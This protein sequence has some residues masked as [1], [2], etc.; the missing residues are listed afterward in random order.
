MYVCIYICRYVYIYI[1]TY[2]CV[3]VFVFVCVYISK[4]QLALYSQYITRRFIDKKYSRQ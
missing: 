2:V 3:R 4:T 1:Y